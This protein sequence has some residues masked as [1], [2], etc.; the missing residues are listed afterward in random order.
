MDLIVNKLKDTCFED[1]AP[2]RLRR[3]RT[4]KRPSCKTIPSISC[5]FQVLCYMWMAFKEIVK[6]TRD[7]FK[8]FLDYF[9]KY[10]IGLPVK[11]STSLREVPSFPRELWNVHDQTLSGIPRER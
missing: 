8:P 10:Y 3:G 5:I 6:E 2:L 1:H 7:S 4:V 9:E 11:V